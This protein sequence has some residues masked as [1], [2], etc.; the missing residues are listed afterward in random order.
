MT[1]KKTLSPAKKLELA[2]MIAVMKAQNKLRKKY[3]EKQKPE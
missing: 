1:N 2:H 3:P